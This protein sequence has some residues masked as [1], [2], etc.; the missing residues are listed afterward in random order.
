MIWT[1]G[2]LVTLIAS[3]GWIMLNFRALQSHRL[4]PRRTATYG[5]IWIALFAVVALVAGHFGAGR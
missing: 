2:F 3:L 4:S 1:G 5:A